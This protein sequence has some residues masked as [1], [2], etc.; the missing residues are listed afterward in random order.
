MDVDTLDPA[1]PLIADLWEIV[2][3]VDALP[4]PT[5]E[6][7]TTRDEQLPFLLID[8]TGEH[9]RIMT[10]IYGMNVAADPAIAI[11]YDCKEWIRAWYSYLC[12][13]TWVTLAQSPTCTAPTSYVE[14]FT[15]CLTVPVDVCSTVP[16]Y[17]NLHVILMYARANLSHLQPLLE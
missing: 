4:P 5:T 15:V 16:P 9:A 2:Q 7:S 3:R 10:H 1:S 12:K 8:P 17:D 13:A 6:E 11:R 14:S